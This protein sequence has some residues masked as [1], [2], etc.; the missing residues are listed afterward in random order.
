MVAHRD[1]KPENLMLDHD[2]RVKL[3]DFGFAARMNDGY[4]LSTS[5]GSPNYAAPEIISGQ[6]YGG[7]E[8]DVWS[9]GVN[10][11]HAPL[12]MSLYIFPTYLC[13]LISSDFHEFVWGVLAGNI[14]RHAMWATAVR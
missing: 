6:P 14:V 10:H 3:V 4:W 8:V 12:H 13:R 9:A 11:T 2:H 5:C 1:L 7:P